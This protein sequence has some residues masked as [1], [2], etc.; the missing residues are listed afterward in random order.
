[1][2]DLPQWCRRVLCDSGLAKFVP[3]LRRR[4]DEERGE[5]Q[6]PM[7]TTRTV[8]AALLAGGV[9]A[10]TLAAAVAGCGGKASSP[11][12]SGSA[13]TG[14][15]AA[16]SSASTSSASAQPTDYTGLLI[17]A[18]DIDAPEP[19]TATPPT[20]NPNGQPG[21]ATTFSTQDGGRVIKDTI[22]V[23]DDPAAATNALNA[24]KTGQG[25]AIKDPQ[26]VPAQVGAGAT[27]LLG[28]S[29]DDSKGVTIL[30]F[31]EGRALVTLEFDGPRD[32]LAPPEFVTDVGNKQDAA[33]KKG[34]GG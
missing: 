23:L 8:V 6:H 9:A 3:G 15:P 12:K 16:T 22:Q 7:R 1:M 24:A 32:S 18:T 19:F 4:H 27:T 34:L 13:T 33:V 17:Q 5:E 30:L 20:K 25:G 26:T 14:S 11:A 28:N 2:G 10:T 21:V 31:T 29:P